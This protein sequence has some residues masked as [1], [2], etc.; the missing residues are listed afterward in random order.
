MSDQKITRAV[1]TDLI[2]NL[3]VKNIYGR[4]VGCY[5]DMNIN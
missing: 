4:A 5:D 2:L 3:Y 1:E